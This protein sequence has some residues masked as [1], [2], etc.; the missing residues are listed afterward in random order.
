MPQ[1]ERR[2]VALADECAPN[3]RPGRCEAK[4]HGP[5]Q[6]SGQDQKDRISAPASRPFLV[7]PYAF[8]EPVEFPGEPG[9]VYGCLVME[10]VSG[11]HGA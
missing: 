2:G 8:K 6:H 10:T 9:K 1:A 3:S 5:D 11:R 7:T 4:Q